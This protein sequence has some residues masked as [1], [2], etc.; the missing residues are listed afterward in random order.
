MEALA[1]ASPDALLEVKGLGRSG[2]LLV[3]EA[4]AFVTGEPQWIAPPA[5]PP[6]RPC[7]WFDLEAD[8][9]DET[10]GVHVYLWGFA[11]ETEAG[12]PAHQAVLSGDGDDRD[13][14]AWRR[15]L[16]AAGE[17][18]ARWPEALWVHYATFER[19]WVKKYAERWG[20][21]D[22]IAA[23]LLDRLHDLHS[24]VTKSVRLPLRSYGIK[25]V[26]G[27]LGFT[28]RHPAGAGWSLVQYR[29]ARRDPDPEARR[30]MLGE[31]VAY[32][33]DDLMALRAVWSWLAAGARAATV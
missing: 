14:D 9:D 11:V 29:T 31:I 16:A 15:F 10:H 30:R 27:H 18:L 4:R 2:A 6:G 19:T 26:A 22:G 25:H 23:R 5:M 3:H 17:V 20:D 28:W 24:E 8:T 13:A 1:A 21:P 7:V 12:P 33:A 32:N